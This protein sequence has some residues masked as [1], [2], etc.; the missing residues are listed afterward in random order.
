MIHTV[1]PGRIRPVMFV[2][3]ATAA[4]SADHPSV[5][6][7][8]PGKRRYRYPFSSSSSSSS[9]STSFS[10]PRIPT[11]TFTKHKNSFS[12]SYCVSLSSH[13]QKLIDV[14]DSKFKEFSLQFEHICNRLSN[15]EES[16]NDHHSIIN[17]IERELS[18]VA[19][20]LKKVSSK[21]PDSFS[22]ILVVT[23]CTNLHKPIAAA[24]LL[25]L[26]CP[27]LTLILNLLPPP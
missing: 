3:R 11:Y 22:F 1:S 21:I 13:T 5:D 26:L 27:D 6:A 9:S 14:I 24:V 20:K 10:T 23:S 25:S 19:N 4:K 18:I 15:V 12:C 2:T 7:S 17:E 8:S 16:I